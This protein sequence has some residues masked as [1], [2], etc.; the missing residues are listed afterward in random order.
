MSDWDDLPG[1]VLVAV[2]TAIAL[3]VAALMRVSRLQQRIVRLESETTNLRALLSRTPTAPAPTL[4]ASPTLEAAPPATTAEPLAPGG[5][6][7]A[8]TSPVAAGPAEAAPLPELLPDPVAAAATPAATAGGRV[9]LEQRLGG[10]LFVWIGG[11]ALALAALFLVRYAI[12]QGY[13]SPLVR[14]V[15]ASVFG[16][17]LIAG[18]DWL[19]SRDARIA[20]ALAGAGVAS[21]FGALL[22][23]VA[24]YDLIPKFAGGLLALALTGAAISLSLRHGVFVAALGLMGG[25]ISPILI[26]S[27][28]PNIPLLLGYLLAISAGTLAV[29]R[30]RGWWWLGWGVLAGDVLWSLAWLVMR[31]FKSSANDDLI[32]VGLFQVAVVGLFVWATWRR[33]REQGETLTHVAVKVAVAM[34][35]TGVLLVLCL[36]DAETRWEG[37]FALLLHAAT[38]YALARWVPRYQWLAVAPPLF[39]LASFLL[40]RGPSWFDTDFAYVESF[41]RTIAIVGGLLAA[42]AMALL[43][44]AG[45]PGFWAALSAA[46]AFLHLLVAYGALRSG[47]PD[48][49]WGGLSLALALPYLVVAERLGRFRRSMPGGT[50][51]LGFAAVGVVFFIAAAVPLELQRQWITV[52]YALALPM[53]A[54]IAW[55]LDLRI[56]RYVCWSIVIAVAVR[57]VVNPSILDYPLGD[58]PFVNWILYTY[59]IAAAA[60]WIA[61]RFL[62]AQRRDA[63]N[64]VIE[65][66]IALFI[67]LLVT[68]EIRSLF[69]TA[70]LAAERIEFFE[71]ATYV[72][73]WGVMA[74][75]ILL[76]DSV[77]PS[78]IRTW[79][80]RLLGGVTLATAVLLQGLV[81]NP[82]LVGG[83]VGSTPIL[84]G[85]LLAYAL[86]ALLA[87]IAAWRLASARDAVSRLVAAGS[88]LFLTFVWLTAEVRHGFHRHFE[89]N[90]L[91]AKG[92]ELYTYSIVW[93]AFGT[94]LTA[95]GLWRNFAAARHAGMALVLL[96][97][98]KAFLIDMAGL[99]G[100]WR[101]FSFL[102]L[103]AVLLALGYF[104]RRIVLTPVAAAPPPA[105][106]A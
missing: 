67:F 28:N 1:F 22:A 38:V 79:A 99:E 68:L 61:N 5:A 87:G 73:A 8:E 44:N 69:N 3:A 35:V 13:L 41:A 52:A 46:T 101:V 36:L 80:W 32:W 14:V 96:T 53:V 25:V 98:C 39:S 60:F 31:I 72:A 19:R 26:G 83:D 89:G 43:W 21:L 93:L 11:L 85:L 56:L 104:Y 78:P 81:L 49:A 47:L 24:L 75:A 106:T 30:H 23:A 92:G 90:P 6:W 12:D 100:L 55:K 7:L 62:A 10:G 91:E 95:F 29:I 59:G 51:A 20:Q 105:P 34:I 48:T 66:C 71:R 74:L 94:A 88:A 27:D 82:V 54:W 77:A 50:E 86:P 65:A 42:G 45:R 84:N 64:L 40:W 2:L 4:E 76:Y 103:G 15:L 37:W 57:L 9:G 18:A 70:T 63:L 58:L 16:F 97:V 17:A 33:L 102:G